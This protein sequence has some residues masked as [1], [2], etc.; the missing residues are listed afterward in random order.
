MKIRIWTKAT[1]D[2]LGEL[3]EKKNP[4][5][6]EALIEALPIKTNVSKWGDEIYFSI[7]INC[8]LENAQKVVNKGE[9]G[10]WPSGD[11]LCIFFGPTPISLGK[12]IKPASPVTIVGRIM[13]ESEV[14][15]K[16]LENDEIVIDK[17][18]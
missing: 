9:I 14:L 18:D 8:K 4:K 5:T 10:Y 13:G 17:L 1:G 3:S 2:V 16:V 11:A 15:K 6:V 7:N 12:E